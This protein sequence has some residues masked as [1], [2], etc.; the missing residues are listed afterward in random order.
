M[1]RLLLAAV[2]FGAVSGAHAADM[3]DFSSRQLCREAPPHVNWQ[4]YYI[5]GQARLRHV[6]HEF[7]RRD[8]K[9]RGQA[10]CPIPRSKRRRR[11]NVAGGRQSS[12]HGNGFGGFAGYNSQ[13]DDVVL[14]VELSYLHGKF[15]GSRPPA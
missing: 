1:R 14:G 4:G 3:P 2:M 9:R 5:G 11:L 12:V 6:R 13:W 15:G 10:A 7:H 8:Q